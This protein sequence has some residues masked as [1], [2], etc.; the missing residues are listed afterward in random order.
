MKKSL[1]NKR[2]KWIFA[3]GGTSRDLTYTLVT[4]FL[5]T[6]LQ[7]TGLFQSVSQFIVLTIIIFLCR[8]WDAINDPIMGTIIANTKSRFGKYRPW[9]LIGGLLN[10]VILVLMFSIRFNGG[11]ANVAF[12]GVMYL[13][14][15]MTFTI[16][17][18]SYWG[19]I[20]TLTQDKI[21]R[22]KFTSL[23]VVFASLGQ[24]ISGGLVPVITPGRAVFM[25]KI[26]AAIW[27]LVFVICQIIIFFGVRD[28]PQDKFKLTKEEA[29]SLEKEESVSLGEMVKII[30]KNKQ[31]LLSAT[32]LFFYTLASLILTSIGL[33]FF[34]FK[35]GYASKEFAKNGGFMMTIFTVVFAVATIVSQLIYPLLAKKWKRK[36]LIGV[37]FLMLLLGYIGFFIGSNL[38]SGIPSFAVILGVS[39]LIFIGQGIMYMAFIIMLTNTI[40]YGEWLTGKNNSAVIFSVRPFV[41]KLAGALQYVLTVVI[42]ILAGL[43]PMTQKVGFLE[44]SMNMVKEGIKKDKILEYIGSLEDGKN[45]TG[46]IDIKIEVEKILNEG[47]YDPEEILSN[48][49][50]KTYEERFQKLSNDTL[51]ASK[52]QIWGLSASM[53]IIPV[54]FCFIAWIIMKNKYII[55]ES[56]YEVLL[57]DIKTR[58]NQEQFETKQT[59]WY[60][61]AFVYQI[62]PMSFNDSNSD[63]IGDIKGITEKLDYLKELGINCVWLSP[64]YKSPM[65][66]NGYDISDYKDI[67]PLFGTMADFIEM[68]NE[69]HK[70]GIRLIMDLVINHTSS[71][72]MWFKEAK[73]SVDSPYHDYY[74]WRSK[75]NNWTGFFGEGAWEYAPDV[76]KYYLHLFAKGQPDLNWENPKVREEVKDIMRFWF[77]MGVDGFRCDVINLISK[78]PRLK[79]GKKPSLLVG[80]ENFINGPKLHIYLRE[81]YDDVS[82]KYDVMTVGETVFTDLNDSI[83][84]TDPA[85]RELTMIFNFDHTNVDNYFG[86]KWIM[87]KFKLKRLKKVLG[88]YQNGLNKFVWNSLFYENHDQRRSIGRFGTHPDFEKEGA[89]MLANTMYFM[90]GTPFIYQ[91]QELG[92]KNWDVE[93][94]DDFKDIETKNVMALMKKLPL[95]KKYIEKSIRNGSRDNARTPM[96]WDQ[97]KN[98]G[99]TSGIPWLT[100]NPNYKEINVVSSKEDS[101]SIFNYYKKMIE[102][103][104]NTELVKTG[105]YKDINPRSRFIYA[106]ER[107]NGS[108]LLLVVSNFTRKNRKIKSL[109]KPYKNYNCKILLNNY[110]EFDNVKLKPYQGVVLYLKKIS[111]T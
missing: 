10:G 32:A 92:M 40:E 50:I 67:N 103:R 36:T 64:V 82:S 83:M 8:I 51:K 61:D 28:N 77:D 14:W 76:N 81:L 110:N 43:Y 29:K 68:L 16:N 22:D 1:L 59:N 71:E 63:G 30:L 13:L 90:K 47:K 108:E 102:I 19:L 107:R 45:K 35:F 12:V 52:P 106:Y 98:A 88:H 21:E 89:K 87:R 17:D 18:I 24:F 109:M 2:N 85:R 9:I 48:D 33:N 70:R 95:T 25:Y 66:D 44:A 69:M 38:L 84:L 26:I 34:W 37:S 78:S 73:K 27:A 42:L 86:I 5:L 31:L 54:L 100:V 65:E 94:L 11:W 55:D 6:Y 101:N 99:F 60:K 104:K 97:S 79:N 20:P 3:T 49:Q 111:N 23:V 96:Q 93:K 56:L 57:K 80:R 58:K 75:P 41:V 15:G 91:G 39:V 4:L 105:V 7:Y 62:Y 46:E 74:I 53:S 72:H